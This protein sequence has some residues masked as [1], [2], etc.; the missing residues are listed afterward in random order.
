MTTFE[1]LDASAR[2]GFQQGALPNVM[3]LH[4]LTVMPSPYQ[5]E[6]FEALDASGCCDIMV[7]Y[8]AGSATD[9]Q[10]RPVR[11]KPYETILPGIQ[12]SRHGAAGRFNPAIFR[13]LRDVCADL[14][15]ISD[16]SSPTAQIAMRRLS[17]EGRPWVY[18]GE[19]PNAV[20]RGTLGRWLRSRLQEPILR[21]SAI[22]AIGSRAASEYE[23]LFPRVPV[24]NMPYFCDL[25][26][27][28]IASDRAPPRA[29]GRVRFLFSG[30]L[31]PR[32]GVDVLI[33]AFMDAASDEKDVELRILGDGPMRTVLAER[34]ANFGD[35]IVFAGHV[36]PAKL[37][38]EFAA[39]D[40]FVLPSR[41]DGWGVVLNEALGAGLPI[42]ASDAVGAAHDLV[43]DG[44]NGLIAQ[45]GDRTSLCKALL[46]MA[47][48]ADLRE[49]LA[50][51]SR[52]RRAQWSL[53]K[54]ARR[55]KILTD[56]ICAGCDEH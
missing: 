9:R 52:G 30:Q 2:P 18:W 24:F 14:V 16:Y 43:T 41:Y 20:E 31:I 48:D 15:V 55:W 53:D 27:F 40:V 37:P 23:R 36:E 10:W 49:E 11:L 3:K 54:A 35:R 29:R 26:R 19:R 13:R 5:R 33:E 39:A 22:L 50:A 12:L 45:A 44:V 46:V 38:E 28:R 4:F 25:E 47:E 56:T 8:F 21:A 17:G 34:T 32:K 6:T 42:I 7:D 1:V 51:A